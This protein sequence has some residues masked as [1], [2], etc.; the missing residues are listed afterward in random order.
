MLNPSFN[1][2]HWANQPLSE[3]ITEC[4]RFKMNETDATILHNEMKAE[5]GINEPLQN[6]DAIEEQLNLTQNDSNGNEGT[7]GGKKGQNTKL[8]RAGNTG[9]QN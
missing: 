3:F 1:A 7:L 2:E 6:N 8:G 5:Q 9:K 4:E